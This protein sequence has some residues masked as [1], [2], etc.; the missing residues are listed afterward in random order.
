MSGLNNDYSLKKSS[1]FNS[2]YKQGKSY[3]TKHIVMYWKK[4]REPF[5]RIGCTVSKK[6]GNAVTRNR[7]KRLIKEAYRLNSG[8]IPKGYDLVFVARVRMKDANYKTTENTMRHL[9][10]RIGE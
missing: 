3:V 7:V 1:E 5:N 6:V 8:N 2:V 10:K 9:L 4:N